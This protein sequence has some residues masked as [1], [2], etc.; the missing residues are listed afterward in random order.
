MHLS[1]FLIC[2]DIYGPIA[3]IIANNDFKLLRS[4]LSTPTAIDRHGGSF[5]IFIFLGFIYLGIECFIFDLRYYP[6]KY[7]QTIVDVFNWKMTQ[8]KDETL[9]P[10][11]V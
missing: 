1:R 6:V 4:T 10:K 8:T 5:K 9:D 2:N 11:D 3:Q 7:R